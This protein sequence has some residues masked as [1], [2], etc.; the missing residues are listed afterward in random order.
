[1]AQELTLR[2]SHGL[3]VKHRNPLGP[4]VLGFFTVGIYNAVWWFKINRELRDLGRTHGVPGL[5]DSPGKSTLAYTLGALVIVPAVL[6]VIGTSGRIRTAQAATGPVTYNTGLAIA[7]WIL[8]LGI[9]GLIY[10][11]SQLNKVYERPNVVDSLPVPGSSGG[12]GWR[13]SGSG[14][15]GHDGRDGDFG[16]GGGD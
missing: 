16:G 8:T 5:G 2:G 1:M 14:S 9:G 3:Q 7:L 13:L 4:L 10:T 15:D 6:T 12:G 11:Q